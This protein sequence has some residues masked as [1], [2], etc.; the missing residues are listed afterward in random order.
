MPSDDPK[1]S[2]VVFIE[3]GGSGGVEA[4]KMTR[5]LATYL[6]ENGFVDSDE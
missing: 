1:I 5:L 2:F 3:H 4:A 6:K